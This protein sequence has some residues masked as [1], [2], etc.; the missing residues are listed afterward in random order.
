MGSFVIVIVIFISF[1][2]AKELRF[3]STQAIEQR[4]SW[5]G[6][7]REEFG[8]GKCRVTARIIEDETIP[9][10]RNMP[11]IPQPEPSL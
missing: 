7:V 3:Q 5:G 4:A 8:G 11:D 10:T 9:I 1:P 2:E 6:R